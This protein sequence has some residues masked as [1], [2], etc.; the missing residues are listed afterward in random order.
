MTKINKYNIFK[1]KFFFAISCCI[2]AFFELAIGIQ[3]I[4][5]I[6]SGVTLSASQLIFSDPEL[7]QFGFPFYLNCL[8]AGVWNI[9]FGWGGYYSFKILNLI[10]ILITYYFVQRCFKLLNINQFIV[11]LGYCAVLLEQN[12][13]FAGLYVFYHN[14]TSMLAAAAAVCFLLEGLFYHHRTYLFVSGVILG[15]DVFL[16]LSN[17]T[18]LLVPLLVFVV[19]FCF[20][21]D[22]RGLISRCVYV[23]VG[24]VFG[25][26]AILSIMIVIPGHFTTFVNSLSHDM[27]DIVVD[28]DSPHSLMNML[29]MYLRNFAG[30]GF[31][32]ITV[33]VLYAVYKKFVINIKMFYYFSLPLLVIPIYV[34][35]HFVYP[36]SIVY[37]YCYAIII[38]NIFSN[39]SNR[40]LIIVTTAA[41]MVSIM[42]IP[43]SAYGI[44][45][46][47]C[48][49]IQFILP[50]S[51]WLAQERILKI[52]N[53][54]ICKRW[55]TV[56][57]V[58]LSFWIVIQLKTMAKYGTF[59]NEDNRFEMFSTITG[60]DYATSLVSKKT[61]QE[62]DSLLF[63]LKKY[64]QSNNFLL[65][66][67]YQLCGFYYLTE[68]KPYG[69]NVYGVG[70][71]QRALDHNLPK[72][73]IV[74][75][76]D[77]YD[78]K[79]DNFIRDYN[80]K[81]VYNKYGYEILIT[82]SK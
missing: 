78:K 45:Y 31:V 33:F 47:G 53:V 15:L 68:S 37:G 23:L 21:K 73:V 55:K 27:V 24:Y 32:A 6:D 5:L 40:R 22:R 48:C 9:F 70:N 56:F 10:C 3:G 1:S 19:D 14:F 80:Y 76:S 44:G 12:R 52:E 82:D 77:C 50:L 35:Y 57:Y 41:I 71:L 42:Q 46:I 54:I 75:Y 79:A 60:S 43:G 65:C 66:Y 49:A 62:I 30:V 69:S 61:S 7:A 4:D 39:L 25:I 81:S 8:L 36:C 13:E 20:N 74:R 72:P 38:Y 64:N 29:K 63:A 17:A 16:R 28:S 11:F 34:F 51:F 67:P 59:H 26:I 18:M 2:I 58:L